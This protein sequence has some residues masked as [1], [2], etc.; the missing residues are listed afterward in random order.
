MVKIHGSEEAVRDFMRTNAN[1][2]S[3]NTQGTGYWATL[4]RENPEKLRELQEKGRQTRRERS[5]RIKDS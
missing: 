3:R 2:S 4:A 5:K 1:K